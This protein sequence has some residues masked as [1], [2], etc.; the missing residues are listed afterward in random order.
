MKNETLAVLNAHTSIRK[1][2]DI[3]IKS[4]DK[5]AIID[6][7]LRGATAGNMMLYSLLKI[8][9]K[10]NLERLSQWCDNQPF[11]ASAAFGL[12]VLV[13][14]QKWHQLFNLNDLDKTHAYQGPTMADF[15]LGLQDAMIAAQNAVIAAES[16]EIGT[17]YIGDILENYEAIRAHFNLPDYVMPATLIVFGHYDHKPVLK[18]RFDEKYVVFSECYPR[19]D[20]GF[21]T[22]MFESHFKKPEEV[23]TFFERKRSSD[24]FN[25]MNRSIKKYMKHFE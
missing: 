5:Q 9:R 22:E 19:V 18:K 12:M 15:T 4:E 13:D 23:V 20:D 14:I 6:A 11:I 24:F 1:F 17:C 8:E 3:P 25:E 10:D 16:L 2:N 21:V 7:S